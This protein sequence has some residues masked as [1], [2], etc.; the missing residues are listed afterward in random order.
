MSLEVFIILEIQVYLIQNLYLQ[1]NSIHTF[2]SYLKNAK[3]KK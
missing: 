1:K 2:S 3:N